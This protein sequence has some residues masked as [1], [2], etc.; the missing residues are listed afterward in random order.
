LISRGAVQTVSFGRKDR[1]KYF[2]D[3]YQNIVRSMQS[4][5][6]KWDE[7]KSSLYSAKEDIKDFAKKSIVPLAIATTIS[8]TSCVAS[9]APAPAPA[10][11]PV[12][13]PAQEQTYT[14]K[15]TAYHDYNG[16]GIKEENEPVIPG[17]EMELSSKV[18]PWELIREGYP[19]KVDRNTGTYSIQLETNANG[20][21]SIRLPKSIYKLNVHSNVLGYNDQ[22]FRYINI[23]KEEFRRIA[24]SLYIEVNDNIEKDI[25]LMQGFLTLPF[26]PDTKFLGKNQFGIEYFVD[27]DDRVDYVRNWKGNAGGT[28]DNHKGTDFFMEE[29]TPILAAAPGVVV[30]FPLSCEPGR[31]CFVAIQH[32]SLYAQYYSITTVYG[33]LNKMNVKVGDNVKR[34]DVI[35]LS[36]EVPYNVGSITT[37]YGKH[38]HF[39]VNPLASQNSFFDSTY[40][41]T[42]PYRNITNKG[43]QTIG[44]WTVDNNPQY[45]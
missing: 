39:E 40:Y 28:Y 14:V 41:Y 23:S 30:P 19:F 35:G 3:K 20:N 12:Q 38:L 2:S 5:I 37:L 8:V 26:G 15:G 44:F 24:D 21:Y 18:L 27:M 10:Q 29:N 36:G 7:L 43:L 4:L 34:G 32:E 45:P 22:P 42:D 17:L 25:A 33:H 1:F 9:P 16:D 13:S 11:P 6:N 31:G